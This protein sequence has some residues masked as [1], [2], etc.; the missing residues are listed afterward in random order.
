MWCAIV[1]D[2]TCTGAPSDHARRREQT[3]AAGVADCRTTERA[4]RI[5]RVSVLCVCVGERLTCAH[6]TRTYSSTMLVR[7]GQSRPFAW[8]EPGDTR[9]V[10]VT[11][12]DDERR[13]VNARCLCMLCVCVFIV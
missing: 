8:D 1:Y 5:G 3:E 6:T 10:L 13:V 11:L 2:G 12:G 9:R 7:A 4:C